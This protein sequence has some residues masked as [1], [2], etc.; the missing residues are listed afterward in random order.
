MQQ[1]LESLQAATEAMKDE[2]EQ[3]QQRDHQ[4]HQQRQQH[5][6]QTDL[7]SSALE[8]LQVSRMQLQQELGQVQARLL[9]HG[10][11]FS[12]LQQQNKQQEA[13][14]ASV[15]QSLEQLQDQLAT[16]RIEINSS[17][18]VSNQD[19]QD[20]RSSITKLEQQVAFVKDTAASTTTSSA[21]HA[22]LIQALEEQIWK[23]ENK[24][25]ELTSAAVASNTQST[26]ASTSQ[27]PADTAVIAADSSSIQ[28]DLDD[29]NQRMYELR[30]EL[31]NANDDI[32][33]RLVAVEGIKTDI[34]IVCSSFKHTADRAE[35]QAAEALEKVRSYLNTSQSATPS[36]LSEYLIASCVMYGNCS[37]HAMR[38]YC[39]YC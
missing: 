27:T 13:S 32:A 31:Q 14:L 25:S 37:N 38:H 2:V 28:A 6:Q 19:T 18:E 15:S 29:L 26:T 21:A 5:A 39:H 35:A 22:A 12:E 23:V 4:Q 34:D 36:L 17:S 30:V 33:A 1:H 16:V 7:H 20:I 10:T 24:L 11:Q 3:Q 8:Q 9:Q